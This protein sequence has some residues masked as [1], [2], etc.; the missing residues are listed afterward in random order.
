MDVRRN[1]EAETGNRRHWDELADVHAG[2]YDL[3]PLCSGGHMLDPLQLEEV[4][5]VSG[6]SLLH[7][8]C[9][10]GSDTLSW[11]R[12]GAAVTGVD[13]SGESLR[14]A[15][16]LSER[17][18]LRARFIRSSVYDLD[19]CLSERFDIVYTSMGVLCWLSDLTEWA[20][21]IEGHLV[22][23]G[24]LYLLESHPFLSAFDDESD[25]LVVRY[26]YFHDEEPVNW[27]DS[28]PDYSDAS[29][30]VRTPSW[31]W[32]WSLSD[33]INAVIDAGLR[34]EF[35]HEHEWIAWRHVPCLARSADGLYRMPEGMPR[36]PLMFSLK[37]VR[38]F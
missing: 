5:D 13:I 1:R 38:P 8:Q 16:M 17:T 32:T 25:G 14:H 37:A 7:L 2:S 18:G 3:S 20:R 27:T 9:H 10:I 4:G 19:D 21:I 23:G 26:G 15:S 12:L 6:R 36:L 31:E 24:F 11:A 28:H 34:I 30:T 35:I 33:V 29:Y 22:P